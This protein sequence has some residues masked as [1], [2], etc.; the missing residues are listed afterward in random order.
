MF[1]I[2]KSKVF[3][4]VLLTLVLLITVALSTGYTSQL[5]YITDI[6]NVP[7]SPVQKFF[8]AAGQK[9]EG[10][11]NFF[12]DVRTLRQENEILKVKIDELENENRAL[13]RHREE[14]KILRETLNLKNQ[15]SDYDTIGG[16]IIAKDTGNWFNIFTI[17]RGTSEGITGNSPVITSRGLV[18]SIR[19][20]GTF[21]SKVLS[22]ID[23]DSTISA[24]ISKSMDVVRVRGDLKLKDRGLCRMDYIELDTDVAV[25]DFIETSG[26]GGIFPRGILIGK[27]VGVSRTENSLDRY[28]IVQ[29]TV[30]FKKL[31][32]VFVLRSKIKTVTGSAQK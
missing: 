17:D 13:Q 26:V 20:A 19:E 14:N 7:L 21:S 15:F 27:V 29:P 5:H 9:V 23:V 22:I 30:D 10:S 28:A 25:G 8:S 6:I 1:R 31:Q 4:L 24:V 32:E 2:F 16:N 3:L 18:G 11:L 12:G